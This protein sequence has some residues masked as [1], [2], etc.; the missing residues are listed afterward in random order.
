MTQQESKILGYDVEVP[1]EREALI[2]HLAEEAK[3]GRPLHEI[4]ELPERLMDNLYTV[5]FQNYER[6]NY[7]LSA[8]LFRFLL[9]LKG[10]E[11]SYLMG[12]AAS[13]Q[14]LGSLEEAAQLF[15]LATVAE[16]LDPVAYFHA[17]SCLLQMGEEEL[18]QVAFEMV[19][20][21]SGETEEFSELKERAR[22]ILEKRAQ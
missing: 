10:D 8:D 11:Y 1:A 9:A 21:T 7:Q 19:I 6:G 5:A 20:R 14:K 2:A 17:G 18:A 12:L 16:P 22:L 15:M 13:V 4:L 3:S